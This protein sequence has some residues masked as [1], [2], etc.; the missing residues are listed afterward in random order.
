MTEDTGNPSKHVLEGFKP[1]LRVKRGVASDPAGKGFVA[2]IHSWDNI[3]CKGEPLEWRT[4]TTFPT[5]EK[6]MAYYKTVLRPALARLMED[7]SRG[8]TGITVKR[9]KLE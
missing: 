2:I 9:K 3:D 7:L 1:G 8:S 6:A 5:E 4:P